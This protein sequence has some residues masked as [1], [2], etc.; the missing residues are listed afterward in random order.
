M[1]I[2]TIPFRNARRKWART[3]LLLAVF[4]LGVASITALLHVSEMV[5]DSLEK[6]LTAFGA[7]I[8]VYP[9]ADTVN[10]SYGGFS[11]GD[12]LV[13]VKYLDEQE[14]AAK[15]RS[16]KNSGNV[17]AVAPKLVAMR[18]IDGVPIGVV[19]VRFADELGIKGYWAVNGA[20]PQAKEDVLLGS[21]VANRLGLEQGDTVP[22]LGPDA[23]VSGVLHPTGSD[24]DNVILADLGFVQEMTGQPG[25]VSFVEVAA[26]CSGCPIEEITSQIQKALPGVAVSA[27]KSVVKQRM[28]SVNFVKQL[29]LAVSVVILLTAC[30]MV[31]LSMLSSVSERKREIGVLRSL[32]YSRGNVFG[33][34]C[35]EAV[36]IGVIAGIVGYAGGGLIADKVARTLDMIEGGGAVFDPARLALTCGLVVLLCVVS[37][38]YPA[39][40]ASRVEPAEALISL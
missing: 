5:G 29:V 24:D 16:I 32:G 11:L 9:K 35:F 33:I 6:K 3:L 37:A 27:V 21:S 19:G 14:T 25:A 38:A 22:A 4:S 12:M 13:D 40:K 30:S 23:V 31:G 17:A 15:I 34:F 26:L 1:N 28:Y 10:V 2:L 8:L 36:A 20:Y 18:E 7:N 39:F